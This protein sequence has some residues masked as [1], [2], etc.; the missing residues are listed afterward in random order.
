M[1]NWT[2]PTGKMEMFA[3]NEFVAACNY[4]VETGKYYFQCDAPAGNLYFYPD[5]TNP[6]KTQKVEGFYPC[7]RTHTVTDVSNY[8]SGYVQNGSTKSED[9]LVWIERYPHGDA[10]GVRQAHASASLT[11]ETAIA[12]R[13]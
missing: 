11:P 12:P 3:A 5:K 7:G 9:L 6:T 13:S 4:S 1:K 10:D 8:Y 2:A